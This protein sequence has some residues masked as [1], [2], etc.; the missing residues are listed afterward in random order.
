MSGALSQPESSNGLLVNAWPLSRLQVAQRGLQKQKKVEYKPSECAALS[1]PLLI[2]IIVGKPTTESAWTAGLSRWFQTTAV[3]AKRSSIVGLTV[4]GIDID[5]CRVSLTHYENCCHHVAV[6][7]LPLQREG[8]DALC[9]V[10]Y[11]LVKHDLFFFF[12][13]FVQR[14]HSG[15]L[16]MQKLKTHLLRT[17]SS[18]SKVLP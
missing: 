10:N 6:T 12:F 18:N 15:V 11:F 5:R 14:P 4:R 17:H 7:R 16:R 8:V 3:R 1:W 13:V 9:I 2:E